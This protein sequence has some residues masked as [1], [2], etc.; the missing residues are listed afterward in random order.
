MK[1]SKLTPV[2]H[3]KLQKFINEKNSLRIIQKEL[4]L[5]EA[6]LVDEIIILIRTGCPIQRH[7][8]FHLVGV[9]DG[10]FT[11]IKDQT[12]DE[13]LSN[14]DNL[15]QIKGKFCENTKITETML[16]L[17]LN[18]IKVRQ[19]M[20]TMKV[21][22]FDID[23]NKLMNGKALLDTEI[24]GFSNSQCEEKTNEEGGE[25]DLKKFEFKPNINK[26]KIESDI[27]TSKTLQT[28]QKTNQSKTVTDV[29]KFEYNEMK[30]V[31]TKTE[32]SMVK[33]ISMAQKRSTVKSALKIEYINS[34]DSDDEP[35]SKRTVPQWVT[36]NKSSNRNSSR[37]GGIS[38][39]SSL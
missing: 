11:F 12:T 8:L 7:H 3:S 38:K 24:T 35:E 26:D 30:Q 21:P 16:I 18:Y 33:S 9:D 32:G 17:V 15:D 27:E 10:M 31:L 20:E 13:D 39:K 36:V 28:S 14:F 19:L 5:S 29:K 6:E 2:T 34:S 23:E 4:N 37:P 1:T 22:Y 25:I